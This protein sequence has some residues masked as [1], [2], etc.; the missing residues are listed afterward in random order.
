MS[1]R[2]SVRLSV[3]M[4]QLCSH[5]IDFNETWYL[6]IFIKIVEYIQVPLKSDKTNQYFTWRPFYTFYHISLISS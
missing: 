2:M 6:S 3:R 4:E 1:V 5:T